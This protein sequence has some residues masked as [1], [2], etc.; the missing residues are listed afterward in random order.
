MS[1]QIISHNQVN[2]LEEPSNTIPTINN[3]V[4]K[5]PPNLEDMK[6]IAFL[7]ANLSSVLD[8]APEAALSI[9]SKEIGWLLARDVPKLTQMLLDDYPQLRQDNTMMRSYMFLM[10]FLEAVTK[11]TSSLLKS[12]QSLMR[13]LL[14]A[15]K[16]SETKLTDFFSTNI[17]KLLHP[18]FL[19]Y[20]DAEIENQDPNTPME[21]LLVTIKLK[22]LDEQGKRLGVDVMMLPKLAAEADPSELK[23]K[24]V[25]HL[26]SYDNSGKRLFLQTLKLMRK[27]MLKRYQ[28]VDPLLVMNLREVEKIT[29]SLITSDS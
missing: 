5:L 6:Q 19:V 7:F 17:E 21:S 28:N 3:A 12:Q 10:D 20:L 4:P 26:E 22:L 9:A 2:P 18:D 15:A 1:P 16:V 13:A 27:E 8:S 25:L 14:E 29:E 24:T 11:E 23:R